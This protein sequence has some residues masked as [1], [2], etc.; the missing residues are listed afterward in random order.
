MS[1]KEK[2]RVIVDAGYLWQA[3]KRKRWAK[4]PG[5]SNKF[6]SEIQKL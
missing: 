5:K 1:S 3:L 2:I 4:I 6:K